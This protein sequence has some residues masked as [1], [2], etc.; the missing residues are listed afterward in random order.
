MGDFN[1]EPNEPAISD[2][3]E[4][5]NTKNIIKDKTCFKNPENPTCID[6]I[7]TSRPRSF[8]DSTVVE[9][10]FSDFHKMCVTVMKM[11]H[12][13]QRPSVITYRKFKDFPNIEFMKDLEEHLTKFEHFDNIPS[14]LFQ[15]TVNIILEKHAPTKKKYVRANQGP[16]ITKTL[17]KEIM[18]RSRLRNK[19]LNTKSDID[20]KIYN[21]QRNYVVS[22]LRKAK[23]DFY[24]NLDISKVTDN[25]VFLKIVKPKISDK[26]KIRS[27]ITLV[28]D[29]KILSQDAEIAKTF[30]KYFINIQT[31]RVSLHKRALLKKILFQE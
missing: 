23:K 28:E 27:K 2:F 11:Y 30:N 5:Y 1:V 13:K 4:I 21:K 8:Q 7:L 14:N 20:K 10:G 31:I 16:F 12:C 17:S 25:R 15:K 9:T 22:L 18:K 19:F 29:D 3:C 6:L 26:V 24:G